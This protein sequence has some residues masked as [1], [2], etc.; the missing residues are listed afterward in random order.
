MLV[1]LLWKT[2]RVS[3]EPLPASTEQDSA[4]YEAGDLT[5]FPCEIRKPALTFQELSGRSFL[6]DVAIFE[7]VDVIG[8]LHHAVAMRDDEHRRLGRKRIESGANIELGG[9]IQI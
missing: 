1:C 2:S 6:G 9:V 5:R 8:I 3:R 7:D 4:S